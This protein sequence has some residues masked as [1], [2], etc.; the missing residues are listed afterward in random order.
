MGFLRAAT[1]TNLLYLDTHLEETDQE[2]CH[3]AMM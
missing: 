3:A 2:F 1:A